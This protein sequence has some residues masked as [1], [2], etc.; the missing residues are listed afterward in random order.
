MIKIGL[1][2]GFFYPDMNRTSFEKKSLTFVENDMLRYI[3][4]SGVLPVIIPDLPDIALYEILNELDGFV[5]TGGADIAPQSY[6]QEPI[7]DGRWPGDH[8]RDQY[9]LRILD[10]A[11]RNDK[12]VF[13]ICRGLQLLNVYLGGTLYQDSSLQRSGSI[14]HRKAELYDKLYHPIEFKSGS[15]MDKMFRSQNKNQINSA[16]HQS[17]DRLGKN[18]E[19]LAVCPEDGIIE[20]IGYTKAPDGKVFGVQFHPEFTETL[21]NIIVNTQKL[22]DVFLSFTQNKKNK[23]HKPA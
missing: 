8:Y 15:W 11:M 4:Q 9:E 21:E 22:L 10:Y 17:I 1:S 18:L 3:T 7:E 19:V 12:P 14:V 2:A 23:I 16:H 5:F 20:A 13:G 6:G